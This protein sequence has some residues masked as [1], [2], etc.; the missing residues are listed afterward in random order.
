MKKI[1]ALLS[2]LVIVSSCKEDKKEDVVTTK[3][4]MSTMEKNLSKYVSFELT[5][6]L[7]GL[8]E[9]ERQMIPLL[10]EA[11]DKMHDLFWYE[12]YGDKDALLASIED[13]DTKKFVEY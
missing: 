9:K 10:I 12:S 4:E 8:T 1:L 2:V 6:D 7:S 3:K 13:E 11:A 5:A